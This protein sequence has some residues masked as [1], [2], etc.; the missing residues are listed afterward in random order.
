MPDFDFVD[1]IGAREEP[2]TAQ[3]WV[4]IPRK[5]HDARHKACDIDPAIWE[6]H[7]RAIAGSLAAMSTG[8]TVTPEH[9]GG[10]IEAE[11]LEWEPVVLAYTYV[12]D[13]RFTLER[14][15]A[16]RDAL[17]RFG[18]ETRQT[19]IGVELID[20]ERSQFLVI[21]KERYNWA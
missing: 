9:E 12:Q 21:D 1:V 4:Y 3:I 11:G 20:T 19:R 17:Y 18:R 2:F 13:E 14:V 8:V 5:G 6:E 16:L 10:S 15:E 7:K